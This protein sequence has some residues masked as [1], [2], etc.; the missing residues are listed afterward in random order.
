MN[1]IDGE[2][3]NDDDNTSHFLLSPQAEKALHYFVFLLCST[4]FPI[5]TILLFTSIT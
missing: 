4:F 3:D 5:Y 1:D 2:V